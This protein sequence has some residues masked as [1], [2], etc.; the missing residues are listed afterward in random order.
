MPVKVVV[1]TLLRN[2]T[3][4][5]AE[6][7]VKAADI[8]GMIAALDEKYPGFKERLCDEHGEFRSF[9]NV[10]LNDQDIRFWDGEA[11]K[12]KDGD[13]V[14]FVPELGGG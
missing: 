1:P 6:V 14:F 9:V 13:E 2:L 5:A 3:G 7:E 8:R 12:L 11:T 4:S 10:L